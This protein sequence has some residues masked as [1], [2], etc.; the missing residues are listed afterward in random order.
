[1]TERGKDTQR[2]WVDPDDAPEL[3]ADDFARGDIYDG[4]RLVRRG[5]PPVGREPKESVTIRLS[6]EVLNHFR[7]GGPGWQ[8]R[9][10]AALES[11][12]KRSKASQE[13]SAKKQASR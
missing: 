13:R 12:V 11:T 3:T 5:R 9:L 6:R 2:P 7:A 8:T 1:M 4:Q 10:N